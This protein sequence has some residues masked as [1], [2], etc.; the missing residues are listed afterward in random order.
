MRVRLPF[1]ATLAAT[2]VATGALILVPLSQHAWSSWQERRADERAEAAA[3]KHLEQLKPAMAQ[4]AQLKVPVGLVS[5]CPPQ[6]PTVVGICWHGP[7]STVKGA[8]GLAHA[9]QA[10]GASHVAGT[11]VS[12][13]ALG[14]VCRVEA[15]LSGSPFES[16]VGPQ[17]SHDA[18]GFHH[19]GVNISGGVLIP[20]PSLPHGTPI[21]FPGS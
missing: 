14:I 17:I 15:D 10:V 2:V 8:A 11:C 13:R 1:I 20:V 21:P 3:Q 7:G 5:T 16:F 19:F 18:A 9:L 6:P 4:L 12:N